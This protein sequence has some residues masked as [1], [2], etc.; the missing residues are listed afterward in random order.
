M[1]IPRGF[2]GC[3][4]RRSRS[5]VREGVSPPARLWQ[6]PGHQYLLPLPA[7]GGRDPRERP[8]AQGRSDPQQT[9]GKS[10]SAA[11]R[12]PARLGSALHQRQSGKRSKSRRP[13][14][15]QS[16]SGRK[17]RRTARGRQRERLLGLSSRESAPSP[18]QEEKV[19]L[20]HRIVT[21]SGDSLVPLSL[22]GKKTR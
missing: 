16:T 19:Q 5:R 8:T 7:Q 21:R 3:G 1:Q 22:K 10:G 11:S 18:G 9:H 14:G 4:H 17:V 15:P 6:A 2:G 20:V 13:P 12:A